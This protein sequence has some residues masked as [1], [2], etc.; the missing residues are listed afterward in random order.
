MTPREVLLLGDSIQRLFLETICDTLSG[1]AEIALPHTY[2]TPSN[3]SI[4]GDHHI[5]HQHLLGMSPHLPYWNAH[6]HDGRG[7]A[8]R[9]HDIMHA[10]PCSPEFVVLNSGLWDLARHVT[11]TES[12]AVIEGRPHYP[13]LTALQAFAA[14][15][16]S[17]MT[18]T[19]SAL[20][21][22]DRVFMHVF[23]HACSHMTTTMPT[24]AL[25]AR[26]KWNSIMLAGF[27]AVGASTA[28]KLGWHVL[29]GALLQIGIEDKQYSLRSERRETRTTPNM[30]SCRPGCSC[31]HIRSVIIPDSPCWLHC[32]RILFIT[33]DQSDGNYATSSIYGQI[34]FVRRWHPTSKDALWVQAKMR[35]REV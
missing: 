31:Y 2:D 5:T 12:V 32:L 28:T 17:F 23:V 6:Q 30:R 19:D 26:A 21:G 14:N 20:P 22:A 15:L 10:L 29:D 18:L 35:C 9:F 7:A 3:C 33:H 8:T 11:L 1:H 27:N 13:T 16:E 25:P 34:G 24:S 4:D